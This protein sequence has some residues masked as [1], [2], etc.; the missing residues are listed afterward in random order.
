M[1]VTRPRSFIASTANFL[2]STVR[3]GTALDQKVHY[4]NNSL[5]NHHA[6]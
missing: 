3:T 4:E 5:R 6:N 2:Q 1:N